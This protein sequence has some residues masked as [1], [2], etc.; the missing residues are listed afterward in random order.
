[1][2]RQ[3]HPA[4]LVM[5]FAWIIGEIVSCIAV[6]SMFGWF[7]VLLKIA[8]WVLLFWWANN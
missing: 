3:H 5:L 4:D 1:M 7:G 2:I 8:L 6:C